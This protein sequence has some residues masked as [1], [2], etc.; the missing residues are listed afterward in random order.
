MIRSKTWLWAFVFGL[1]ILAALILIFLP[2]STQPGLLG[3]PK[4]LSYCLL[5]HVVYLV[6]LYFFTRR[7][8]REQ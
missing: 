7:I 4:W 6:G 2:H 1:P 3:F 5:I 8:G